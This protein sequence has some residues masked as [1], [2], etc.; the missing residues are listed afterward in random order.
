MGSSEGRKQR[1]QARVSF[2]AAASV[3]RDPLALTIF[4]TEH[5]AGGEARWVTIGMAST[6]AC[7]VVI[8]TWDDIGP[9]SARVRIISARK[10]TQ[11]EQK[12]D[13]EGR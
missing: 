3:L 1:G 9:N 4:D 10:A 13:Q 7:L 11:Q 8:H 5:S 6:G 12:H 2:G